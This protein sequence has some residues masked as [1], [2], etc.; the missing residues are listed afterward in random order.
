MRKTYYKNWTRTKRKYERVDHVCRCC[1]G[2]LLLDY[3]N[4]VVKC[5]RCGTESRGGKIYSDI[6]EPIKKPKR[7]SKKQ[8][9]IQKRINEFVP[10]HEKLPL[11]K[12]LCMC[13]VK[14]GQF[15]QLFICVPNPNK[16]KTSP[17]E[18]VATEAPGQTI[19]PTKKEQRNR[20]IHVPVVF[21]AR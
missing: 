20:E 2:R 19:E 8:E 1:L 14:I 6:M 4:G 11:I 5:A 3:I 18:I 7:K 13:G 10:I 15:D 12:T 16:S 17:S 9:S 21:Q